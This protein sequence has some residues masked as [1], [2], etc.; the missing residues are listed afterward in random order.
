MQAFPRIAKWCPRSKGGDA[1]GTE[2]QLKF[3]STTAVAACPIGATDASQVAG[4]GCTIGLIR[5]HC[6]RSFLERSSFKIAQ[7][8]H[9]GLSGEGSQLRRTDWLRA[10]LT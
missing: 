1:G 8:S 5:S 9:Q 6:S 2:G 7:A 3:E 10:C 4:V